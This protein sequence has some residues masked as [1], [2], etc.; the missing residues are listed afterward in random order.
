M[1]G[2]TV[3]REFDE[4]E[5][6][7]DLVHE[8]PHTDTMNSALDKQDTREAYKELWT[9]KQ[10]YQAYQSLNP[11]QHAVIQFNHEWCKKTVA[12]LKTGETIP[13]YC[14]FLRGPGGTGKSHVIKMV[15]RDVNY[16]FNL[17]DKTVRDDPLVL[18][19][20]YTGTAAFNI[21]MLHSVL[22]LPTGGTECLSDEK[23]TTLHS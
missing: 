13:A 22:C 8:Y 20:V 9:N 14:L 2:Q 17:Y 15:H 19:M 3:L 7:Q 11:D 16:F 10:Y 5:A 21:G 6:L 4:D 18:L 1:E 23:W 12:A